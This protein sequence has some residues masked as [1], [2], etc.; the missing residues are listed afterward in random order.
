M[1]AALARAACVGAT[2]SSGVALPTI[3]ASAGQ[4]AVKH[5]VSDSVGFRRC[6]V[7][8]CAFEPHLSTEWLKLSCQSE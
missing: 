6:V 1:P 2:D 5:S 7:T 4:L 8:V 3:K